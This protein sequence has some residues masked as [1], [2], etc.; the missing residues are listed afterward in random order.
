MSESL[1][2]THKD[3]ILFF[4]SLSPRKRSKLISLLKRQHLDCLSEIFTNFLK[5]NLTQDKEIVKKVRKYKNDIRTIS[6]KRT[7]K[8]EK[9]RILS[10]Q[11]GGAILGALLPLAIS[12]IGS[13]F[14]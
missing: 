11:R 7:P 9:V 12:A 8:K 4:H 1:L 2:S 6:L 3:F 14:G 5:N 13:L 10:S